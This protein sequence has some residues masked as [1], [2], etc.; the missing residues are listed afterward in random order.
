L[1]RRSRWGRSRVGYTYAAV[2]VPRE[3][4]GSSTPQLLD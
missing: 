1:S 2:V 3:S 4:G